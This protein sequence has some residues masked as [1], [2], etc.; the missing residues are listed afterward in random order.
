MADENV[1][2]GGYPEREAY[3]DAEL[4]NDAKTWGML[5]HLAGFAGYVMP[6]ANIFAPLV[7]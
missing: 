1:G 3:R 6:F 4:D 2:T 7:I 5:C